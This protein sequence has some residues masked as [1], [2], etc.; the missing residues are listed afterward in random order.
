MDLPENHLKKLSIEKNRLHEFSVNGCGVFFD[1]S[2]QRVNI[3]I[4]NRLF[5]FAK[6]MGVKEKFCYMIS[7]EKVN[8]SEKRAALHTASRSQ[9]DLYL[10]NINITKD[11][12]SIN[13]DIK[14]FSR[15]VRCGNLKGS[16]GKSFNSI[17]VVGIGGSTLGTQF[18]YNALSGI[19]KKNIKTY[20][21][22]SVDVGN[23]KTICG[24]TDPE[25][26]L[27]IVISKSF[28]TI[29]TLSNKNL[30]D[31]YL[32][33]KNLAPKDHMVTIT[34]NPD[35]C[36]DVLKTFPMFDFV[37]GRYSVTSAVGG[38]PL[39][40]ALGFSVFKEFLE[41]AC[42]MDQ[43]AEK[44]EPKENSPL[45]AALINIWNNHYL[46]YNTLGVIPYSNPLRKI[47]PHLKQLTMESNGK[48]VD[49]DGEKLLSRSGMI[50]FGDQGTNAQHS[51]FQ[52]A[53][54]GQGFP[55]EFIGVVK[56]YHEK[57]QGLYRG[58]TNHQELWA[59]M[60]SQA[61]GLAEGKSSEDKNRHFE[62][63]RPSSTVLIESLSPLNIG[64]LLS[65]YESKTVFEAF[66]LNINPF[67]QFGVE[68]GKV[69]ANDIRDEIAHRNQGNEKTKKSD[70]ITKF[71]INTLFNGEF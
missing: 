20:F 38:V 29:E 18:V 60:V 26:T 48:S 3:E 6:Q 28:A 36:G 51:F 53:H 4:M 44:S 67:D 27:W 58:V 41:G 57:E 7:G 21:L 2:R 47:T 68:L 61:K 31:N 32:K 23:F 22:S 42:E 11:I 19:S 45:I 13:E 56:P 30:I 5:D 33:D 16:T 71:Y 17:V 43:H 35:S 59:N 52:L 8:L 69:N 62:G 37:G 10:E 39:S 66:L 14:S 1:F 46:K 70:D 55:V 49:I 50:V 34:S 24:K 40:I 63:N 54:Q 9:K 65:F 25:R 15:D 12:A 64:K